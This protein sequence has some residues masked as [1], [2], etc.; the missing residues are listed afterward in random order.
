METREIVCSGE[1]TIHRDEGGT[2]YVLKC[3]NV[4]YGKATFLYSGE[5]HKNVETW[6]AIT[7]KNHNIE[8]LQNEIV[9][10]RN[11]IETLEEYFTIMNGAE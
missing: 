3:N 9:R 11:R 5:Y 10:L 7:N 8:Y 1:H 2:T 6:I 4:K